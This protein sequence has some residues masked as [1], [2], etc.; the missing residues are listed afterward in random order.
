MSRVP[1]LLIAT[2]AFLWAVGGTYASKLIDQG[3]SPLELTEARAWIAVV[4]IGLIAWARRRDRR[5]ID[6]GVSR[7]APLLLMFGISLALANLTYYLAIAR[8]PVAVAI[9]I[10]YTAPGLVVLWK[11]LVDRQKP[12]SKIVAA[13][14]LALVGVVLLS[15]VLTLS[16]DQLALDAAGLVAAVASSVTFAAYVLTGE[17]VGERMAPEL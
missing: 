16:R 1:Y 6:G 14:L 8:L 2:A 11:A 15:G 9:V 7:T 3:A 12:T 10:Q 4:G 17:K 5:P 13:L